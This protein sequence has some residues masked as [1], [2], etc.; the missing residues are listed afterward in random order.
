MQ[1]SSNGKICPKKKVSRNSVLLHTMTRLVLK[2]RL[3]QQPLVSCLPLLG[4]V[5][6]AAIC[7]GVSRTQKLSERSYSAV[8]AISYAFQCQK[9]LLLHFCIV[10]K[11]FLAELLKVGKY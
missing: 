6:L 11:A 3:A 1:F 2:K 4:Y 9:L 10:P 8:A 7:V 5:A